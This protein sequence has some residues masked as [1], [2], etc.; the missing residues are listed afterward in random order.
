MK[1]II[2]TTILTI[3]TGLLSVSAF[4]Q[5][6]D[7]LEVNEETKT[8]MPLV[9]NLDRPFHA[10]NGL[11]GRHIALWGSH[12]LY[13]ELGNARWEWQRPRM[14]E[15]CEDLFPSSFVIPYITRMLENAGAVVMMPRER[16][17]NPH[18]VVVDNDRQLA[19]SPYKENNGSRAWKT[20][21]ADG[22]ALTK[23]AYRDGQNPFRDGT[24]RYAE[25]VRD[26][27]TASKISWIPDIPETRE[28]AVYVSYKTVE[29]S[30]DDACYVVYHKGGKTTFSVNQ[31][32]GGG[33]WVYLGTFLF[34]KGNAGKVVLTNISESVDG[35]VTADAVR[36]GGG[37][38]N[39][40]RAADGARI[41]DNT[42]I[43]KDRA[44]SQRKNEW[45]PIVDIPYEVSGYPRYAEGARYNLQWYGIPKSVYSPSNG[46]N[47]YTDDYKCRGLWV[48]YLAG[49]SRSYPS[50][51]GLNIPID[52][53]FAFHTDAGSAERDG[54]IGTLAIHKTGD[55]FGDGRSRIANRDYCNTV[56][57]T[58]LKDIRTLVEPKW[59]GRGSVDKSY[60]EANYPKVPAM[61][62]ELLSHESFG[63]MRYGNDPRFKFL[64]SRAIYK[65]MLKFLSKRCGYDYVV[66]PLP[67]DHF[68]A[69]MTDSHKVRLTW[70]A[71]A[72][73]LEATAMPEQ[74]VVYKRKANGGFDNGTVVDSA[75]YECDIPADEVVSFKVTALNKGGESFPSEILSVG[76][77]SR[78][79]RNPILVINGFDR[80]SAPDDF[81][82][83][84]DKLAGFLADQDDGVPD[85]RQFD[86]VGAQKENRRAMPMLD[87]D[88]PG[89][90]ASYGDHEKM[91]V[92][93]NTFDYPAVHGKAI[94]KA[95]LSFV[96]VSR[97][98]VEDLVPLAGDSLQTLKNTYSAI[99]LILGKQK[100]TKLGRQSYGKLEF[101]TFDN[102][103]QKL[104]TDY[105]Q[106]G[107]A[108]FVSGSYIGTDLWANPLVKSVEADKKFAKNILKYQWRDMKATRDGRVKYIASPLSY[109][110]EEMEIYNKKN[111]TSYAVESPDA[112][113][114]AESAAVATMRYTDT[115]LGAGVAFGG[116][117]KDKWK[118]VVL[119]FP[120]EAVKDEAARFTL[121]KDIMVF[122]L[123]E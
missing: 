76:R 91:V 98:A 2:R 84:D 23:D 53:S 114:P 35:V 92:A 14:F 111:E 25:T 102:D 106:S 4:S 120:F 9:R 47:D 82:S 20:G 59:S 67:V 27:H 85:M 70:K 62:L 63:E 97:S 119:G 116:N 39:I 41:Y 65:G 46:T 89:F 86:F 45:Q 37:M 60:A 34:D 113:I 74:Y 24:Y 19:S 51:K 50:A 93:G 11:E 81:S 99:D 56:Y 1:N 12:G 57:N 17:V 61:L 7:S 118:S 105:C 123:K 22:F 103:M 28:Y 30:V 112:I 66:Q 3:L 107:G 44:S 117:A 100:Q 42:K 110:N 32:M 101:K 71:V 10:V 5:D 68:A 18:E 73:T 94:L 54:V 55:T 77:S 6:C 33:T 90:G 122:L 52:L 13:Y 40:A 115:G 96:S 21:D 79:H 83:A 109:K 80:V 26:E 78:S 69:T 38:G 43:K 58:I 31:Q 49:G 121:M 72:D 75:F 48:N 95:G 15:T 108:V 16:D 88:C 104:L 64:V 29:N 8:E 36:F 87:D